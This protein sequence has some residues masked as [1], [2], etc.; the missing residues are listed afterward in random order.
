MI[1]G[2]R[3]GFGDINSRFWKALAPIS[4]KFMIGNKVFGDGAT[5]DANPTSN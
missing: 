1:S 4:K 3:A 5:L 2:I